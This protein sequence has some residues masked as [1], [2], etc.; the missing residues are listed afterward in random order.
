M[1]LKSIGTRKIGMSIMNHHFKMST[2]EESA[3]ETYE[4]YPGWPIFTRGAVIPF[5]DVSEEDS[6]VLINFPF[7]KDIEKLIIEWNND[8]TK[9][10]G[11][12]ARRIMKLINKK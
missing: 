3:G 10:A 1:E 5:N 9:T 7:Y 12:L 8:N 11:V 6:R 4:K 2:V